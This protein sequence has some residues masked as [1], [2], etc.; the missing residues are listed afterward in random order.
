[1]ENNLIKIGSVTVNNLEKNWDRDSLLAEIM[2]MS[3]NIR[4]LYDEIYEVISRHKKS[5]K[6]NSICKPNECDVDYEKIEF[7]YKQIEK[8]MNDVFT[9]PI[10][11]ADE[12]NPIE[13]KKLIE[14]LETC[15]KIF[16]GYKVLYGRLI[17]REVDEYE[18]ERL[19]HKKDLEIMKRMLGKLP[20]T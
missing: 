4:N 1:M 9:R 13:I 12:E 15:R 2:D 20:E 18:L 17:G 10:V 11:A 3:R 8:I 16:E 7:Y 5:L 6:K 14:I 19:Y